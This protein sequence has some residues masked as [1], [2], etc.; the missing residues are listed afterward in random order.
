[1]MGRV[2]IGDA[3]QASR[4][5]RVGLAVPNGENSQNHVPGRESRVRAHWKR[6]KIDSLLRYVS[7]RVRFDSADQRFAAFRTHRGGKFQLV[8]KA[9]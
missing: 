2:F 3:R 1:M 4:H 6:G 7:F 8:A 9:G 5:H